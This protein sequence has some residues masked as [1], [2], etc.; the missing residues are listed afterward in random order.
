MKIKSMKFYEGFNITG[1]KSAL[2]IV[3]LGV[4]SLEVENYAKL[5]IQVCKIIGTEEKVLDIVENE[6]EIILWLSY[7]QVEV[8]EFIWNEIETGEGSYEVMASGALKL[9]LGKVLKDIAR[10]SRNLS[11]PFVRV[12][13]GSY[14]IGYGSSSITIDDENIDRVLDLLKSNSMKNIPVFAI[15]GTNGKTTTARLLYHMFMKLGYNAGMANT[16]S[17]M[18]GKER[19]ETGDTTGFLSSR[20]LLL[21][22][23]VEAAVLETARGGIINN[24]LGFEEIDGAIITSLSEDHLGLSGV[25]NLEEL[26][27]VKS[28]VLKG[29]KRH[30]AWILRAQRSILEEA[31]KNLEN[32]SFESKAILFDIEQNPLIKEHESL[33]GEAMYLVGNHLIHHKNGAASKVAEIEAIAFTHRGLSLSNV[34]NVMAVLLALASIGNTMEHLVPL[35]SSI[36]C[37]IIHNPGRQN[38]I[39]IGDVRVLIDYGHNPEA[40]K[41]IYSIVEGL[42]PTRVTSIL[43][44]PG[45]RQD[46]QIEELG[47]ISGS[48]SDY[49]VIR[50]QEDQ[51]GSELGRVAELMTKGAFNAGRKDNEVT[52]EIHPGEALIHALQRSVKGEVIVM[53]TEYLKPVVESL[54]EYIKTYEKGQEIPI[55]LLSL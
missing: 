40:Y 12:S 27:K 29:V 48:K 4:S 20:K 24:G 16:G 18:V 5:Y 37:D 45:D 50:E 38:I 25:N 35:I 47:Y 43:T 7:S 3:I 23:S 28:L 36:P 54:N 33:G 31:R 32:Q 42:N 49:I 22:K 51:R 8:S 21:D 10:E 53:F 13:E 1:E 14:Q 30:G 46:K 41:A 2:K 55:P 44:S 9:T 52:Y 17:I 39:E 11:I 15:T 6:D 26:I 34:L 19:I